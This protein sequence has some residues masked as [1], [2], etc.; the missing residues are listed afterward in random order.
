[1]GAQ[2]RGALPKMKKI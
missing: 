1:M 2:M